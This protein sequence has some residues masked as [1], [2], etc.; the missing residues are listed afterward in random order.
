LTVGWDI[1][2]PLL[3]IAGFGYDDRATDDAFD[4]VYA[5]FRQHLGDH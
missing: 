5:F 1:A 3:P 4:R 2:R